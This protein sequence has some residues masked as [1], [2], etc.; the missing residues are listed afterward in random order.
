MTGHNAFS[1]RR[2]ATTGQTP[3]SKAGK[4]G[5]YGSQQLLS[6]HGARRCPEARCPSCGH[7]GMWNEFRKEKT[8]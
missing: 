6:R 5:S 1:I 7:E 3:Q 8:T 4:I 2:V